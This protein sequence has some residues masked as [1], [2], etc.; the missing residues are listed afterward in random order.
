MSVASL[1]VIYNDSK[2]VPA[3]RC[4]GEIMKEIYELKLEILY[5]LGILLGR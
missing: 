3:V 2:A 4:A 1:S 5:Q